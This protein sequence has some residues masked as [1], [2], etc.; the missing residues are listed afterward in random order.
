MSSD[1]RTL[2]E[3]ALEGIMTKAGFIEVRLMSMNLMP[4]ELVRMILEVFGTFEVGSDAQWPMR[5]LRDLVLQYMRVMSAKYPHMSSEEKKALCE[6]TVYEAARRYIWSLQGLEDRERSFGVEKFRLIEQLCSA[7][8]STEQSYFS[9]AKLFSGEKLSY[10]KVSHEGYEKC[11][12]YRFLQARPTVETHFE[13]ATIMC[14]QA[15]RVSDLLK[16]IQAE[17]TEAH[18]DAVEALQNRT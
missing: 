12:A 4:H 14:E 8:E 5:K 11:Q 6:L 15:E 16:K 9:H 10:D 3:H 1:G 18:K 2:S 13:M 17:W 7:Q